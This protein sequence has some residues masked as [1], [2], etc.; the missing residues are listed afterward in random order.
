MKKKLSFCCG[1]LCCECLCLGC[2]FCLFCFCCHHHRHPPHQ[3]RNVHSSP[4]KTQGMAYSAITNTLN[5]VPN[6]PL[7]MV[8]IAVI[9]FFSMFVHTWCISVLWPSWGPVSPSPLDTWLRAW[10]SGMFS[11]DISK[12]LDRVHFQVLDTLKVQYSN[13]WGPPTGPW[14]MTSM[15]TVYCTSTVNCTLYTGQ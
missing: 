15:Y 6:L 5:I 12:Y 4:F 3:T 8:Q 9:G 11:V 13:K 1:C 14:P 2:I 10:I 7:T